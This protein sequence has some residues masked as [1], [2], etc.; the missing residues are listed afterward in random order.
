MNRILACIFP[1]TL[2]D[3]GLLAPLVQVFNQVVHMQAVENEPPA[4]DSTY[5]NQCRKM[6]R[7][8]SFTPAPLGQERDRFMALVEDMRQKWRRLHNPTQHADPGRDATRGQ[9]TR[10][11]H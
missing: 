5:L 2:P 4:T 9:A 3:A 6:G 7:L 8:R 1:E 10:I 11:H